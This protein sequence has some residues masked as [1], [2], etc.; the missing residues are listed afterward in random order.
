MESET[1]MFC[2]HPS[3]TSVI[4]VKIERLIDN[5]FYKLMVADVLLRINENWSAAHT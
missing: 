3:R 5:V 1:D 4:G 2:L